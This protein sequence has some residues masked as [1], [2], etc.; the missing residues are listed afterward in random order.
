MTALA[1][2]HWLDGINSVADAW[3]HWLLAVEFPCGFGDRWLE[4][5]IERVI[6]AADARRLA[7]DAMPKTE[8][9]T[10]MW[11]TFRQTH[12]HLDAGGKYR[13]L[14]FWIWRAA[15]L[16]VAYVE[17]A[18]LFL[19]GRGSLFVGLSEAALARDK[20]REAMDAAGGV[21]MFELDGRPVCGDY[22]HFWRP[23]VLLKVDGG[24]EAAPLN[25]YAVMVL[26][27]THAVTVQ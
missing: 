2:N 26:A 11:A 1:E 24:R 7:T 20:L 12:E 4:R 5:H 15:V 8:R 16:R 6:R 14:R 21:G 19:H 13:R 9:F 25:D 27:L 23:A 17:R 10:D 22:C 18:G 3:N